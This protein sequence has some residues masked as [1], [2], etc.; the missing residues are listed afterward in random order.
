MP[1]MLPDLFIRPDFDASRAIV[2][3]TAPQGY[4]RADWKVIDDTAIVNAGSL[5]LR[6]GAEAQFDVAFKELKPWHVNTPHLYELHLRLSGGAGE[7]EEV[8]TFG[9]RK[10]HVTREG[11]F[12]NNQPF[13]VRGYIR[14]REAHDHPNLENLP[15]EEYYAKNIRMA[16]RH[17]FNFIR[18]HSRVPPEECFRVADRLGIF[19]HIEMRKYF[20]KYQKERKLMTDE[21]HLLDETD[22]IAMVKRLR[23]HPSLMVYCMGNEIDHPGRNPRCKYFY[24]LTKRLDPTR[25]F[26]D[27][28]SRG[29]FDRES[30]DLD[31]QHMGYFYPFGRNYGM[32]EDTQNWTIYGA[33]DPD[34]PMIAQDAEEDYTWKVMRRIPSPRPVLAHEIC[35]YVALRDVYDLRRKFERTGAE[36]PW[37]IDELIKLIRLKGHEKNYT[38]LL[39]AS[40]RF[41]FLSW[42]LGIEAA[43]RSRVLNGFHFLQL[44]D[45]ER[46]ENANGILDCFDDPKGVDEKAFL[47]F[48]GDSV[49]LADLPRR[50]YF[51]GEEVRIPVLLSHFSTEYGGLADFT[52]SLLSEDGCSVSMRGGLEKIDLD[53][54]GRREICHLVL[55]LPQVTTPQAVTLTLAVRGRARPYTIENRWNL[56]LYPNR[57]QEFPPIK[58]TIA[59]DDVR[60][61]ARYPQIENVGTIDQPA[62]L[63]ITSRLS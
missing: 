51:E 60:I 25:L 23:N 33:A 31:V 50:T 48:N 44:S 39:E 14:G 58:A 56:W 54:R 16:K 57:P 27:T 8:E 30:V 52:F 26:L 29:E 6:P 24:D 35:H 22:W 42:K 63:L 37:W 46:Y 1:K 32:F 38:L 15:L 28:C 5:A 53:R 34:L 61:S 45:T 7:I 36:M 49:V 17:G 20:G 40:R 41:Q 62:R 11:L 21:G 3:F 18:F 9:M 19:I 4:S 10:I 13:Y 2:T 12:V 55:R 47:E 59:L 43:R